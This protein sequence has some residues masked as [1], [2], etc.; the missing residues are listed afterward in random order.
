ME[1]EWRVCEG[2]WQEWTVSGECEGVS[3]WRVSGVCEGVSR[4]R[5][6]GECV[7]GCGRSEWR[8]HGWSGG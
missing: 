1:G 2:G 3:R 6:S 7:R 4:W 5:V 8:V